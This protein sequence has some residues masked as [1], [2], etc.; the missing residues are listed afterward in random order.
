MPKAIFY[1]PKMDYTLY[2]FRLPKTMAHIFELP[3]YM[4]YIRV[5][6]RF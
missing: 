6:E 4:D 3:Q 1:L 5:I 2:G